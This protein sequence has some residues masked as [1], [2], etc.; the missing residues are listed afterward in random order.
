MMIM[1]DDYGHG[2]DDN[3]VGDDVA[4]AVDG[5]FRMM[6]SLAVFDLVYLVCSL[7]MFSVPLLWPSVSFTRL[8][9]HF[10]FSFRKFLLQTFQI[11][12]KIMMES[13]GEK[14]EKRR[15]EKV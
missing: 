1:V 11:F 3:N 8:L 9:Q 12:W 7:W 2:D 10:Y 14:K 15:E 4:D 6:M 13:Q 5:V